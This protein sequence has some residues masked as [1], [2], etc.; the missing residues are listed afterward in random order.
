MQWLEFG[1]ALAVQ[2]AARRPRRRLQRTN[3]VRNRLLATLYYG[4]LG[5][6]LGHRYL[7]LGYGKQRTGH[8][9][10]RVLPVWHYDPLLHESVLLVR[11]DMRPG[12]FRAITVRPSRELW[13]GSRHFG[14]VQRRL[15]TA[16]IVDCLLQQ[17]HSEPRRLARLLHALGYAG[18]MTPERLRHIGTDLRGVTF[19]P[20]HILY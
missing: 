18:A 11:R 6:L 16:E 13:S 3:P 17:A 8:G 1:V 7:M 19:R 4:R 9:K 20:H 5:W 2:G 14:P 10:Q 12:W 15:S